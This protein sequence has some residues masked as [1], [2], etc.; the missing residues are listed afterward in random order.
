M[1]V[2]RLDSK[3]QGVLLALA[4]QLIAVDGF[5][6]SEEKRLLS[7]IHAQMSPNVQAL[8]VTGDEM[9][10]TFPSISVR[11]SLL[12]ELICLAHADAIYHPSEKDFISNVAHQLGVSDAALADMENWAAR[13]FALVH[14]AEQFMEE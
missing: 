12:L 9:P 11:S 3:Q 7:A 14:E 6:S 8:T 1:F 4:K 5:L 2:D 10:S 13:Y